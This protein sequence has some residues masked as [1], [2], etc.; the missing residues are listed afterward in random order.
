MFLYLF[1]SL[2]L[3]IGLCVPDL[4]SSPLIFTPCYLKSATEPMEQAFIQLYFSIP[5]F[6]IALFKVFFKYFEIF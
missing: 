3:L 6:S 4:P 5:K 2:N 1:S